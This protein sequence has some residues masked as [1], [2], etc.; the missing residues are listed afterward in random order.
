MKKSSDNTKRELPDLSPE[1]DIEKI[2]KSPEIKKILVQ[3]ALSLRDKVEEIKKKIASGNYNVSS[4]K[5]AKAIIT[6]YNE[7]E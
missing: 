2:G 6:H 3:E 5:I 7:E 4:E 1:I